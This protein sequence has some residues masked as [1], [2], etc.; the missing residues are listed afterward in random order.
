[1]IKILGYAITYNANLASVD[2]AT[3]LKQRKIDD[4]YIYIFT[5]CRSSC[6]YIKY[7]QL[8]ETA[9][10]SCSKNIREELTEC[11]K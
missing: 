4:I 9:L 11:S 3:N 5:L 6:I 10:K 1:M 7:K 8:L 2:I